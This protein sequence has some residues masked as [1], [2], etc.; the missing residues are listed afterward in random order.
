MQGITVAKPMSAKELKELEEF[1]KKV[2]VDDVWLQSDYPTRKYSFLDTIT[3]HREFCSPE[4]FDSL[5]GFV[6]FKATLNFRTNKQVSPDTTNIKC[7]QGS[8]SPLIY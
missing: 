5:D 2:P 3:M 8:H 7:M 6:Q 4:M 1:N